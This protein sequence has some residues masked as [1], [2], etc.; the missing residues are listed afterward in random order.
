KA[1]TAP[2]SSTDSLPRIHSARRPAI[3]SIAVLPFHNRSGS[4]EM[5][6]LSDGIPEDIV[7]DLGR[8]AGLRVIANSSV[9]RFRETTDP[10]QAARELQVEAALVGIAPTRDCRRQQAAL[11]NKASSL[12]EFLPEAHFDLAVAALLAGDMPEFERRIARVLD[13]NPNFA[14]AYAERSLALVSAQRYAEG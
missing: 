7:R 2:P 8:V 3:A 14:Q 9:S 12:D 13:L 10:R 11:G 4:E 6:F 5:R 1:M